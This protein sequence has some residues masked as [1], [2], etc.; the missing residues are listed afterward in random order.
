VDV[1]GRDT[2]DSSEHTESDDV[3]PCFVRD[4]RPRLN[5]IRCI[6]SSSSSLSECIVELVLSV[7]SVND[8]N[9]LLSIVFIHMSVLIVLCRLRLFA[10]LL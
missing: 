2:D 4:L 9:D 3:N 1:D 5:F 10:A 8:E 6:S 7:L